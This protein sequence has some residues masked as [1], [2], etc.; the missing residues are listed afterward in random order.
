MLL[1]TWFCAVIVHLDF[2]FDR[3]DNVE[4]GG[5]KVTDSLK[6]R[7]RLKLLY[8][9]VER[10]Q[11]QEMAINRSGWRCDLDNKS[12]STSSV[13]CFPTAWAKNLRMSQLMTAVMQWGHRLVD[14]P[15][16]C[17]GHTMDTQWTHNGHISGHYNG[18]CKNPTYAEHAPD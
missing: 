3:P 13:N 18:H 11:S 4:W 5:E 1:K 12:C 7:S 8:S 14:F 15:H 9:Q 2:S 10:R 6:S 16:L 17:N